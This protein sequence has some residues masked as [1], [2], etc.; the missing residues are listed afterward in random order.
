MFKLTAVVIEQYITLPVPVR[1]PVFAL[2]VVRAFLLLVSLRSRS[3][4]GILLIVLAVGRLRR[5]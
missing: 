2:S 4:Q 5:L 1:I 3:L